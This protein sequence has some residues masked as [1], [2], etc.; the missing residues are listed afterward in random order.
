M[1]QIPILHVLFVARAKGMRWTK[2]EAWAS[3]KFHLAITTSGQVAERFVSDIE[4][5]AELI[6]EAR[7]G[8]GSGCDGGEFRRILKVNNNEPVAPGR[9][10]WKEEMAYDK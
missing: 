1:C 9:K 3:A 8:G 2:G 7:G 10:N 6:R 4:A 5:A